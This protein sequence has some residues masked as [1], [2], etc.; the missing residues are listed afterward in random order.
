MYRIK[1]I[2]LHTF[3]LKCNIYLDLFPAPRSKE[4]KKN[5][6]LGIIAYLGKKAIRV[7]LFGIMGR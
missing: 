5:N 7:K 3:Y 6:I 1:I 2:I 4:K